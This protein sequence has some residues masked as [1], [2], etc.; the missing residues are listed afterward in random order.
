MRTVGGPQAG[1]AE[2]TFTILTCEPNQVTRPIHNR[3]PVI[4]PDTKA[5]E[6]WMNPRERNPLFCECDLR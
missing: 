4:L 2:T 1:Q 5:Q 3:M 6:D